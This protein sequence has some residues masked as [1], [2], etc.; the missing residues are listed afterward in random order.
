MQPTLTIHCGGSAFATGFEG[1]ARWRAVLDCADAISLAWNG[2]R[3]D[4]RLGGLRRWV[5]FLRT[6]GGS[7]FC[8]IGYQE[9]VGALRRGDLYIGGSNRKVLA[10]VGPDGAINVGEDW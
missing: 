1:L 9:T 6:V 7:P 2:A 4:V 3:V 8:V 10:R 5:A